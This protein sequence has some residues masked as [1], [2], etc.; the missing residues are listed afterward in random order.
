MAAQY[1]FL[2][3][4][5]TSRVRRAACFR[6]SFSKTLTDSTGAVQYRLTVNLIGRE[7]SCEDRRRSNIPASAAQ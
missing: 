3:A 7:T 2:K 6:F 5:V 1:R 4:I